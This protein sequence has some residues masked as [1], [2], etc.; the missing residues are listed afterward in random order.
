MTRTTAAPINQPR[1]PSGRRGT[2]ADVTRIV[3][4]LRPVERVE[5][6]GPGSRPCLSRT[7]RRER[8]GGA[9]RQRQPGCAGGSGLGRSG[10]SHPSP[11]AP[12]RCRRSRR[13]DLRTSGIHCSTVPSLDAVVDA[14]RPRHDHHVTQRAFQLLVLPLAVAGADAFDE[15]T[16][17]AAVD[18]VDRGRDAIPERERD[19]LRRLARGLHRAR[20]PAP[21]RR[22]PGPRCTRRRARCAAPRSTRRPVASSSR[23]TCSADGRPLWRRTASSRLF[24]SSW[25]ERLA[26]LTSGRHE[27]IDRVDVPGPPGIGRVDGFR[28][29]PPAR[30][31]RVGRGRWRRRRPSATTSSS[32]TSSDLDDV[33][34][35]RPR[36]RLGV[37]A[38]GGRAPASGQDRQRVSARSPRRRRCGR[39]GSARTANRRR[40][41]RS[42]RLESFRGA[43]AR[44]LSRPGS[45]FAGIERYATIASASRLERE[46]RACRSRN[47]A[48]FARN[49]PRARV[50]CG[51]RFDLRQRFGR[52][53][54][55]ALH[56]AVRLEQTVAT[57]A[58]FLDLCLQQTATATEVGEH[59]LARDARFVEHLASLR[60]ARSRRSH[61]A[62]CSARC[63]CSSATR[64][65]V[66]RMSAPRA[67]ASPMISAATASASLRAH[68]RGSPPPRCGAGAL[69]PAPPP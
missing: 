40:P 38:V 12:T 11:S 60:R 55:R 49:R 36:S 22:P 23:R 43:R 57:L 41:S 35:R 58:Q 9:S 46:L 67:S 64:S 8:L 63:F 18:V 7:Q 28:E 6:S 66:A 54:E 4:M 30:P 3:R 15:A 17:V 37:G 34:L 5:G 24:W 42:A 45:R 51:A 19:R 50:R 16:R 44:A 61:S 26:R 25:A 39:P 31:R 32:S 27:R 10:T 13:T 2:S 1:R 56:D 29:P 69:P 33:D 47:A 52:V 48:L 53:E 68:R 59:A 65:L 14:A 21:R 62:S 20:R